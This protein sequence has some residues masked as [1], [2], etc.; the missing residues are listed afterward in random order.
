MFDPIFDFFNAIY[1]FITSG[2]YSLAVAAFKAFVE[3]WTLATIKGAIWSLSFAWDMAKTIL[4]DLNLSQHI[5]SA[6]SAM[7]A[8]AA[9]ALSYFRIPEV[10]NNIATGFV[11]RL[12]LR[13][14][15]FI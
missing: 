3:Y 11:M 12:V 10:I 1:E 9:Q 13:F 14:I 6:W 2:I 5:N 8:A 7:P 15:P 4:Q